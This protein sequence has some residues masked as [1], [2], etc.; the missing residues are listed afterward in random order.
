MDSQDSSLTHH[1]LHHHHQ[2]P[3]FRGGE[4]APPRSM[5]M[6]APPPPPPQQQPNYAMPGSNG[7][8]GM[9]QQQQQQSRVFPFNS[10]VGPKAGPPPADCSGGASPR[11]SGFSIE[12][13]VAK[14]KRGRPRK[15]SP[16]GNIALGLSPSP[17]T[18]VSSVAAPDSAV[19]AA[20]AAG[21]T[22]SSET[23]AK[24]IRGRPPGSIKKQ[25]DALGSAGV[26][27]TP[28]VITVNPGEDIAQKIMAFSQ[29]G[30][31]TV[32][33]LSAN[34]AISNVTLRQPATCGGTVTLEGRFEI[35]SLSGSFLLSES[36]GSRSRSGGLSVS[37]AGGDGKVV[38]GG[39]SGMLTAAS[40]VQVVVGSFIADGKRPKQKQ[41]PTP[42]PPPPPPP[43][44]MLNFG[45][46]GAAG[47]S[48][49]LSE[50]PSSESEEE[51]SRSPP[52]HP[53]HGSLPYSN[54]GQPVQPMPMY[55]NMGWPNSA[56]KM[57]P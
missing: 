43:S 46:P 27:F 11:A 3:Q 55:A 15:Y 41:S 1:H 26:G 9:M 21:A 54:A 56:S 30:P 4:H 38:G 44:N 10:M 14:K 39:V 35:I 32:C 36:N 40:P 53:H 47:A 12:P 57:L 52:H 49:P 19:V 8:G 23:Q 50:G 48:S 42:A 33:I 28:H 29:Q 2:P 6:S 51:N 17:V 25:L 5:M 22:P 16:D 37:L 34:G 20:T 7:G 45:G 24:K 13:A 31:R 18:P